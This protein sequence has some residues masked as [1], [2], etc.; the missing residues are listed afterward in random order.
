M[1]SHV[2]R[3][4]RQIA[5]CST[6]YFQDGKADKAREQVFLRVNTRAPKTAGLPL[7]PREHPRDCGTPFELLGAFPPTA[8]VSILGHKRG[9]GRETGEF[10]PT[11]TASAIAR[12]GIGGCTGGLAY[13]TFPLLGL[14]N[15]PKSHHM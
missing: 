2:E 10:D 8:I 11:E 15:F 12:T 14:W 5:N 3:S 1:P 7:V 9:E 4:L 13:G 6:H